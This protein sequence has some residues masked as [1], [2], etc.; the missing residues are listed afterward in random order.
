M[1]QTYLSD[2]EDHCVLLGQSLDQMRRQADNMV[3]LVFNI[4][5]ARQ[6]ESMKQLI[7]VTILFLPLT[8]LTGNFGQN[9]DRF[10]GVQQYSDANFWAIAVP[11]GFA[12]TLFLMRNMFYRWYK[13]KIQ[14]ILISMSRNAIHEARRY[15]QR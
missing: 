2:V 13:S 9:L 14:R 11:V 3:D 8:F 10:S 15:K 4:H 5:G 7:I 1:T 6:N 12:T